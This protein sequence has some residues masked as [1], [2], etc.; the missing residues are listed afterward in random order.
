MINLL[1]SVPGKYDLAALKYLYF[2]TLEKEKEGK[3]SHFDVS[4]DLE[5][6]TVFFEE[7]PDLKNYLYCAKDHLNVKTVE[8]FTDHHLC[9]KLD[10]G[11]NIV[12]IIDFF[13]ENYKRNTTKYKY[14]YDLN[15]EIWGRNEQL[16]NNSNYLKQIFSY[17]AY[18]ERC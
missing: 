3:V 17:L 13:T 6:K 2:N 8:E 9:H 12:E 18:L 11:S 14:R 10:Y 7:I 15:E 16:K 5:S 4:K 1:S